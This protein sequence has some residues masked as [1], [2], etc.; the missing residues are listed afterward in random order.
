MT[1]LLDAGEDFTTPADL[2]LLFSVGSGNGDTNCLTVP[3]L[4]DVDFEGDHSFTVDI[5]SISPT[6]VGLADNAGVAV[7]NIEDD[8]T[9]STTCRFIT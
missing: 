3:I 4:E 7:V 2:N 6:S 5:V 1:H 9:Y 8:G